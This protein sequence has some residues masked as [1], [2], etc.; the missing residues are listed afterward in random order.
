MKRQDV[1]VS[2]RPAV[3]R[4]FENNRLANRFQAQAYEQVIAP[5]YNNVAQAVAEELTQDKTQQTK[6]ERIAA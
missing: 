2:P 6:Q 1:S 3:Q 5:S 4:G